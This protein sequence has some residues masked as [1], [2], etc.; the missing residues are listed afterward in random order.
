LYLYKKRHKIAWLRMKN[1]RKMRL[2]NSEN[3]N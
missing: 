1:I 2:S 3:L